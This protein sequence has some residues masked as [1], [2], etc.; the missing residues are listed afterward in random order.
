MAHG[1][2]QNPP[3]GMDYG[4][5]S[6]ESPKTSTIP[7]FDFLLSH[8]DFHESLASKHLGLVI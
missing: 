2:L 8:M 1:R 7:N 4:V 5:E 3:I 6:K